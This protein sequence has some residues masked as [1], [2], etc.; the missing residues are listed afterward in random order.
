MRRSA[1]SKIVMIILNLLVLAASILIAKGYWDVSQYA[2]KGGDPLGFV[3]VDI[4]IFL[5]LGILGT[6]LIVG[7][8]R[9]QIPTLNGL[10]PIIG[11]PVLFI[12]LVINGPTPIGQN[13][14]VHNYWTRVGLMGVGLALA[15]GITIAIITVLNLIPKHK[16][17]DINQPH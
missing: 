13:A 7:K 16:R 5:S 9:L 10:I 17:T 1:V 3:A 14:T 4:L 15:I 6:I 8:N 2:A 11:I 12:P